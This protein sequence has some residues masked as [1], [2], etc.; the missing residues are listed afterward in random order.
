MF[1]HKYRVG[2]RTALRLAHGWSQREAA[3]VWN[4]RWPD[5][6]KTF[7]NF[8]Y[9]EAWPSPTGY[10]PSLEVLAK[11]AHIYES[12]VADLLVDCPDFRHLDH[13]EQANRSLESLAAIVDARTSNGKGHLRESTEQLASMVDRVEAIDVHELARAASVRA[14]GIE[15]DPTRRAFLLK[16]SAALALAAT[17]PKTAWA[18]EEE[19]SSGRDSSGVDELSGIWCSTYTFFSSRRNS[20]MQGEHFVVL[21]HEN[22]RLIGQSLPHSMGSRLT[23]DLAIEKPVATGTWLEQTA[24][25]GDYG[26]ATYHGVLQLFIDPTCRGMTG[27]WLGFGNNFE[28]N[29]G[30]WRFRWMEGST[31]KQAQRRYHFKA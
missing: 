14:R 22:G 9:W 17:V 3:D 8:S 5:E 2:P 30:D 4:E 27:K 19:T 26:G 21:R 1:A 13:M 18:N 15:P 6:P 31:S 11:L 12:S 16:L 7:K 29:S 24:P 25:T 23:L 20:P 10:T 28:I